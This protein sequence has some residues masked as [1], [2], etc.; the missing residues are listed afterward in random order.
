MRPPVN[1]TIFQAPQTLALHWREYLR[2]YGHTESWTLVWIAARA[3]VSAVTNSSSTYT[4]IRSSKVAYRQPGPSVPQPLPLI[5][6]VRPVYMGY[7]ERPDRRC[8]LTADTESSC[9]PLWKMCTWNVILEDGSWPL[10]GR[11]D[12]DERLTQQFPLYM[13][14]GPVPLSGQRRP[15]FSLLS[16]CSSLAHPIRPKPQPLPASSPCF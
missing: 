4:G 11:G 15:F 2:A 9:E 5:T 6:W 10:D 16:V 3:R 8:D 13:M 12:R 1:Y 7:R 14:R